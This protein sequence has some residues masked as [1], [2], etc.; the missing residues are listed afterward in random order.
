MIL[1]RDIMYAI[2]KGTYPSDKDKYIYPCFLDLKK[3]EIVWASLLAAVWLDDGKNYWHLGKD[4]RKL[5]T[6]TFFKYEEL[7]W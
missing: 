7:L 2:Y 5:L 3:S 1:A 6:K 4:F